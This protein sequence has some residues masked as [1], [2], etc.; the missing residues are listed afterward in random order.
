MTINN[1]KLREAKTACYKVFS[2]TKII[3]I[4]F[5]QLLETVPNINQTFKLSTSI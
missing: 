3:L 2:F 5:V 1:L 4:S